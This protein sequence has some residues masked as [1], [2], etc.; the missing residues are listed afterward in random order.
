MI[1]FLFGAGASFGSG[2]VDPC[3]PPLGNDL[4]S[5]LKRIYPVTWGSFDS[6][7]QS[8]FTDNFENGMAYLIEKNSHAIPILMQ[9]MAIFFSRFALTPSNNNLYKAL[10]KK[11][12]SKKLINQTILS[13]LNYEC[14]CEVAASLE[15]LKI[16]YFGKEENENAKIWKIHGSCNFKLQGMEATRGISFGHGVSFGGGIEYLDPADVP[17]VYRGNT[18]LYPS[19]CLYVKDKPLAIAPGV[20]KTFQE[21]WSEKVRTAEKIFVIGVRPMADD[22][23]IW[24]PIADS[25]GSLFFLGNK[26][27]YDTWTS[28]NRSKKENKYLGR[29]WADSE[30]N[31]YNEL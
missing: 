19:M 25:T 26:T 16:D 23:H 9:Q 29:R 12:K 22:K 4:Y 13:T 11:L 18:A 5:A 15:G 21:E 7:L 8:K 10:F 27:E 6:T 3:P 20:I 17:K 31:I 24:Q 1:V 2:Q 30:N 28:A 14:I